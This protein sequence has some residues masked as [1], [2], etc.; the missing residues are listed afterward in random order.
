VLAEIGQAAYGLVLVVFLAVSGIA[1]WLTMASSESEAGTTE[2][3]EASGF[4][5][6]V[7]RVPHED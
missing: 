1:V 7:R 3:R 2:Q 5:E 4:P 6:P